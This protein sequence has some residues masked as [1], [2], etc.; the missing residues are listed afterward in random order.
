MGLRKRQVEERRDRILRAARKLIADEGVASL[1]M[2]SLA[3]S[4]GLS[5]PT[6]YNHFR[7]KNDILEGLASS[8]VDRLEEGLA[9]ATD[10]D[11]LER[12]GRLVELAVEMQTGDPDYYRAMILA[13]SETAESRES[14]DARVRAMGLDNFRRALAAGLVSD[15]LDPD[16]LAEHVLGAY[17][18]AAREWAL[19]SITAEVFR[20]KALYAV[21]LSM[22]ATAQGKARARILE[23]LDTVQKELG[24]VQPETSD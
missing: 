6:L 18:A 9:A 3:E 11:P 22:L 17:F 8:G 19:G 2:R 14:T 21:Y 24:R 23:M 20:A 7:N 5:V 1:T 10:A 13:R 4:A 12:S 15:S 16:V